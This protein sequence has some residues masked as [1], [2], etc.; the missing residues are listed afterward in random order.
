LIARNACGVCRL[1][2]CAA[3]SIARFL[4]YA[5][6]LPSSISRHASRRPRRS[7]S[8]SNNRLSFVPINARS[9]ASHA[10]ENAL[11]QNDI[12][13]NGRNGIGRSVRSAAAARAGGARSGNFQRFTTAAAARAGGARSGDFQR[14]TTA[15]SRARNA[16]FARD[17]FKSRSSRDIF[18]TSRAARRGENR[19]IDV[20]ARSSSR[21]RRREPTRVS[22]P[23]LP[24]R[25]RA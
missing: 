2:H 6:S 5:S 3:I 13:P 8:N 16:R 12:A 19:S 23:S 22:N 18:V 14:F 7:I 25:A 9:S 20:D 1:T 17:E 11:S 15:S 21:L 4:V 24:E 10:H